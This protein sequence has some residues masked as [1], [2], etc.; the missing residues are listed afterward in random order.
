MAVAARIA[1][2]EGPRHGDP[3]ALFLSNSHRV[4]AGL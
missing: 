4:N 1:A 3:N 2:D